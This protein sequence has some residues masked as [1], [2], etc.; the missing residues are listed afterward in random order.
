MGK[1]NLFALT[2]ELR[3]LLEPRGRVGPAGRLERKELNCAKHGG[4]PSLPSK[5]EQA[6]VGETHSPLLHRLTGHRRAH[7]V[8]HHQR[9][10]GAPRPNK[11]AEQDRSTWADHNCAGPQRARLEAIGGEVH[12]GGG[13]RVAARQRALPLPQSNNRLDLQ[14]EIVKLLLWRTTICRKI[15][16]VRLAQQAWHLKALWEGGEGVGPEEVLLHLVG[17]ALLPAPPGLLLLVPEQRGELPLRLSK[18]RRRDPRG[19]R[20]LVLRSRA[21][22]V[23]TVLLK[24]LRLRLRQR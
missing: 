8:H 3:S 24:R 16:L 6:L 11:G 9:G 4:A 23:T 10:G 17:L 5:V 22:Q 7:C 12:H 15:I 20:Q 2:G 14:V 21:A 18:R 13:G 19:C 1:L